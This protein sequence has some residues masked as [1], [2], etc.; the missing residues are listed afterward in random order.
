M[1]EAEKKPFLRAKYLLHKYTFHKVLHRMILKY[2]Y[3]TL[4]LEIN[5]NINF[6]YSFMWKYVKYPAA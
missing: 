4:I 1:Y 3:V 6:Y 2:P 5:S